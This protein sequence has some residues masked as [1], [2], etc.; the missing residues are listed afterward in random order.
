MFLIMEIAVGLIQQQWTGKDNGKVNDD[1]ICYS[2]SYRLDL[3]SLI[4]YS[5]FS[6]FCLSW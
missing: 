1:F 2:I 3:S 6:L 4:I 5:H